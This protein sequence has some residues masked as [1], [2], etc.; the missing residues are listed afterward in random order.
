MAFMKCLKVDV[1]LAFL[2]G[3][4]SG[5]LGISDFDQ[6]STGNGLPSHPVD[7]RPAWGIKTAIHF[8]PSSTVLE[9]LQLINFS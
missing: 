9:S 5:V 2:W 4:G 7:K 3:G 8:N 1:H 6:R